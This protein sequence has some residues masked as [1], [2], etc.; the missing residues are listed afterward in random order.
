MRNAIDNQIRQK[1]VESGNVTR[2]RLLTTSEAAAA[3][4]L[5]AYELRLGAKE[6]R[7]PVLL[8]GSKDSSF[9]R[10][11][12]NLDVL[13]EALRKQMEGVTD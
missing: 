13:Q 6:G 8:I 9:R 12:W 3:T 5:S 2:A 10:M 4:G 11:R 7:Y 1:L